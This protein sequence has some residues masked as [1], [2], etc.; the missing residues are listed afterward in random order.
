M[1]NVKKVLTSAQYRPYTAYNIFFQLEREFIL[2]SVLDVT[3]S[4][5]DVFDPAADDN[6]IPSL[7]Q[8]YQDII[9]SDDWYIPGKAQRKKRRHRKSH[10]KISFSD[11]SKKVAAAWH[12][13]DDEVKLFC[14]EVSDLTM[15]EYKKA[16]YRQQKDDL[17]SEEED[18]T[19][20]ESK[21]TKPTEKNKRNDKEQQ[22]K[23]KKTKEEEEEEQQQETSRPSKV[24]SSTAVDVGEVLS[25][26]A[27]IDVAP[28]SQP[29][30]RRISNE[31][32]SKSAVTSGVSIMPTTWPSVGQLSLPLPSYHNTY[33]PEAC[34]ADV[35]DEAI[36]QMW[37]SFD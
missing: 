14:A 1:T 15:Q 6:V 28:C 2:Q 5:D 31:S 30:V 11:L 37:M 21:A 36:W 18:D 19:S 23:K 22:S 26:S 10:G 20:A 7:P 33:Y 16:L 25:I 8:R 29:V 9:L 4:V 27:M 34:H 12:S 24:D 17:K 35:D 3:P 13:C 32:M